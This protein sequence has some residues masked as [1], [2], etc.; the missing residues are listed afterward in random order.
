MWTLK[1]EP[2]IA[3]CLKQRRLAPSPRWL[4]DEMAYKMRG[5][6]MYV[7]RAADNENDLSDLVMQRKRNTAS[8]LNLLGRLL[9]NKP[10][11]PERNT[12]ETLAF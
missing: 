12:T 2:Q 10:V 7:W 11:D 8:A 6:Q 5:L 3:G 4:L 1:F 9:R